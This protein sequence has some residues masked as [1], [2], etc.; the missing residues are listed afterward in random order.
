MADEIYL[1][2]SASSF[3]KSLEEYYIWIDHDPSLT[4]GDL[5]EITRFR[6]NLLIIKKIILGIVN[7]RKTLDE[8]DLVDIVFIDLPYAGLTTIQI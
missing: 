5:N 7:L 6:K 3:T 1:Y 4:I 8:N 2:I